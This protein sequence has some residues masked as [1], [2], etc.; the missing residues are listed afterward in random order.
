[1]DA[2][3]DALLLKIMDLL[4]N[5]EAGGR[6]E[7]A[8][9]EEHWKS[10][11]VRAL[12]A[13]MLAY[14]RAWLLDKTHTYARVLVDCADKRAVPPSWFAER[15]GRIRVVD[16]VFT[17]CDGCEDDGEGIM[18]AIEACG[19][20]VHLQAFGAF[21]NSNIASAHLTTYNFNWVPVM[22]GGRSDTERVAE[23]MENNPQLMLQLETADDCDRCIE[24]CQV[25][26]QE[27][28]ARTSLSS[29]L[30]HGVP[31]RPIWYRLHAGGVARTIRGPNRH[32]RFLCA[33]ERTAIRLETDRVMVR[34]NVLWRKRRMGGTMPGS[35]WL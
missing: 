11:G 2:L 5:R 23:M 35:W 19:A 32:E 4:V 10:S 21:G 34:A 9:Y 24:K 15:T 16:V 22:A 27:E 8:E 31:Q 12:S 33:R 25:L 29:P 30:M 7:P 20:V 13:L 1:M 26:R 18:D 14:R 28:Q 6:P 17:C 3:D